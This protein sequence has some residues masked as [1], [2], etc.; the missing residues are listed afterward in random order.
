MKVISIIG[1]RPQFIKYA[2][3]SR[4]LKNTH[5]SLLVHTGQHYDYNMSKIFFD[6]LGIAAPEYNL[7]I[8]SGTHAYQTGEML[9]GIEDILVKEKPDLVLIY[10]DTNSTLAGALSAVKLQIRLAH[11]EAG[12]R[13]YLKYTPEEVNR[14][15]S[16]YCSDYL[17]CPT[18]SSIENLKREN[19]TQGVYL[20]G[21]VMVDTLELSRN[22][23]ERSDILDKLG[24]ISKQ[25]LLVTIHRAM[26]TDSP[27][28]LKSIVEA[29]VQL[30]QEE[31]VVFPVHPRTL[32]QL[33]NFNLLE[34]LKKN[35]KVIEPL[36]YLEMIK[37]LSHARKTLTDSGGLQKEAYILKV[38]CI[39]L[40]AHSTWME[41]VDDGWNVLAGHDTTRIVSL[42]RE[43]VPQHPHSNL[44]GSGASHKIA[45]II[46]GVK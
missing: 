22:L 34:R 9:K 18:P 10:G 21:D 45:D 32:K 40:M 13:S 46:N 35:V 20:T 7:G 3:V 31:T 36:G 28:I 17:F 37:A 27:D 23:A 15:V 14:V 12:L 19:I 38:P 43:F 33:E 29:L 1:A 8:G 30:G 39:T 5:R 41:T 26:N 24:L 42:A 2:T 16:D 44:F 25:Y 4:A 6:E 11:V